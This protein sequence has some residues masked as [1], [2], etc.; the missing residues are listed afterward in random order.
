MVV[1]ID[2]NGVEN[3]DLMDDVRDVQWETVGGGASSHLGVQT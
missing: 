3:K 1:G 2:I